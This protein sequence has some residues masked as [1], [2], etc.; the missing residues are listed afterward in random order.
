MASTRLFLG[1]AVSLAL[2]PTLA[3]PASAQSPA[4]QAAQLN[5]Q[6]KLLIRSRDYAGASAK[7]RQAIEL[8]PEGR[9]YLNFCMSLYQEGKLGEALSACRAVGPRGGSGDQVAQA[10]NIVDQHIV[11]QMRAAGIDPDAPPTGTGNTGTGDGTGNTGTGD[12]TGNTGTGNTGTGDGTGNTGTGNTGTGDGTGNTG[13]GNTG[14]GNTGTGASNFTVAPPPSL[15]D[16]KAAKPSHAYTWTLGGQL[17][18]LGTKE[19][20]AG[21]Y[22]SGT[23]GLRV[24]GDYMLSARS[25]FGAQGYLTFYNVGADAGGVGVQV[26]DLGLAAYKELCSR[27]ICLKPLVGLH[28]GAIGPAFDDTSDSFARL[29]VR[30]E[31]GFEYALGQ[32][33]ENVITLG[34]GADFYTAATG[35]NDSTGSPSFYNLDTPGRNTYFAIGYTRRFNTPLGSSPLFTLQ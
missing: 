32:R 4:D 27:R 35:G 1:L 26:F 2:V 12:G 25:G 10:K 16:Q 9:F 34:L 11:P 17:L 33:F 20:Y 22:N 5:E 14:T 30:G 3:A 23:A 8:S 31:L 6:G 13:T 28:I 21:D 15:F 7:F 24:T 29:G 18:A 19:G